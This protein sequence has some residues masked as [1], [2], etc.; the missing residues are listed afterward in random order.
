MGVC[1]CVVKFWTMNRFSSVKLWLLLLLAFVDSICGCKH[2]HCPTNNL[3]NL[4]KH[5]KNF[6]FFTFSVCVLCWF[7]S[8]QIY[9]VA[10]IGINNKWPW[11]RKPLKKDIN[12]NQIQIYSVTL[13]HTQFIRFS[14]WETGFYI[15]TQ[16]SMLLLFFSSN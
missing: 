12:N 6:L 1:V 13:P 4:S 2:V 8:S 15:K 14:E 10:R 16:K 7:P 11:W 3:S 5:E 9:N